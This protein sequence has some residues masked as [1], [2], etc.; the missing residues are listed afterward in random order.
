MRT[1][2]LLLIWIMPGFMAVGRGTGV[3]AAAACAA[4][5]T[6]RLR[7][8]LRY[9]PAGLTFPDPAPDIPA[10]AVVIGV[11][12][13]PGATLTAQH[14]FVP[15]LTYPY[16]PYLKAASAEYLLPTDSATA[17]QWYG[18]NFARCGYRVTG[19]GESGDARGH[20]STGITFTSRANG[21]LQVSL[22][23]QTQAQAGTL[24]LYVATDV[25]VPPRQPASFLPADVVR[26]EV[27]YQ[28]P[29]PARGARTAQGRIDR[30]IA[31]PV[32]I[33]R[34]VAAVNA[35]SHVVAGLHT[36][37][38]GDGQSAR[39]LF[40]RRGGQAISVYDDPLC[41]GVVVGHFPALVDDN[42]RVW[43]TIMALV[44]AHK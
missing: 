8:G 14:F 25:T 3:Q 18:Q 34:L 29:I 17:Q 21:N 27:A 41:V 5:L 38:G 30:T 26:V 2:A 33:G 20:T 11:P 19:S 15:T 23:F 6:L 40:V 44:S 12:L 22:S 43:N 4:P 24:V 37:P 36:C 9:A 7:P 32:A 39:L 13:Y 28:P 1:I 42:H 31:D 16:S 10:G 35:L